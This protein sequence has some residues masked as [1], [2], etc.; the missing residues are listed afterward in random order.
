MTNL[1]KNV[2]TS[3]VEQGN[4]CSLYA[5]LRSDKPCSANNVLHNIARGFIGI[6]LIFG[7]ISFLMYYYY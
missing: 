4:L 3:K 7:G 5:R 2:L 6:M 1:I